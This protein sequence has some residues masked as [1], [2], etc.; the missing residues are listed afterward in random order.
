[1]EEVQSEKKFVTSNIWF[2]RQGVLLVILGRNWNEDIWENS[3][4]GQDEG[5]FRSVIHTALPAYCS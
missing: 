5:G 4:A 1:M 3:E 2:H